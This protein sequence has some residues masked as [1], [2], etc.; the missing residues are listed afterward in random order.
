M[1]INSLYLAHPFD[2]R[3]WMR[4][5]EKGFE[6]RTGVVLNN[7]FYD[8]PDRE[9]VERIDAGRAERY[10]QLIASDLV[11]RDVKFILSNGGIVA[12]I[13]GSISYGT[14]MEIVYAHIHNLPVYTVVTNG[15]ENHPWLVY[16][17]AMVFTSLGDFE[18]FVLR[19]NSCSAC[20]GKGVVEEGQHDE[21]CPSCHNSK[22][23][24][25]HSVLRDWMG[26]CG[27]P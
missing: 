24:D 16:H 2:T 7:P 25:E 21:D 12:L 9:D 4:V 14:I 18:S 15:H 20:G 6:K 26:N 19:T 27:C 5:W 1:K 23:K 22:P 10:E 13:D 11:L 17:S 3:H 8:A